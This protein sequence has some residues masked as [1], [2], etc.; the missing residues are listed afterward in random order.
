VQKLI[1]WPQMLSSLLLT[2]LHFSLSKRIQTQCAHP[3]RSLTALPFILNF[4]RVG[5]DG[6]QH[7]PPLPQSHG[8]KPAPH[9]PSCALLCIAI[10]ALLFFY[11]CSPF[12]ASIMG[13]M[14]H[15]LH[16]GLP[17]PCPAACHALDSHRCLCVPGSLIVSKCFDR[18]LLQDLPIKPTQQ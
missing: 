12:T 6:E 16:L 4:A 18:N 11:L 8:Y 13:S 7:E 17:P 14:L 2:Q 15:L 9:L 1:S 5:A 3:A 10:Q